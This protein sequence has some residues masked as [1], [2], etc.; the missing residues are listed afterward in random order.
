MAGFRKRKTESPSISTASL[1]DIV[2]MLLF[3]FMVTTV[4]RDSS[5]LVQ[6]RLPQA[7][8]LTKLQDKD[9][10]SYIYIG[11]P[12]DVNKFGTADKVQLQDKFMQSPEDIERF[13]EAERGKLREER[14]GKFIISLKVDKAAKTGVKFDVTEELRKVNALKVN[15]A[16]IQRAEVY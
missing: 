8:E 5:I 9:V 2:F 11:K 16:T 15:Y 1:P 13:V 12:V 3:F 7:T 6:N 10:V 14:K 4:L